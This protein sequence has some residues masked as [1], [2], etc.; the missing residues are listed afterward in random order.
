LG[1]LSQIVGAAGLVYLLA[2]QALGVYNTA[3][4]FAWT[5]VIPKSVTSVLITFFV[6]MVLGIATKTSEDYSRVWFFSWISISLLT[7]VGFRAIL[8]AVI[9]A[10]LA[11]GACLQRALIVTC[12]ENTLTGEQLALE[13]KNRIRAVGAITAPDLESIP[14]LG[15]Y[16]R[17]LNP[18]VVVLNLPWSRADAAMSKLKALSHHAVEVLILPR[19]SDGLQHAIRVRHLGSQVL[20][21]VAEPPLAAWGIAA[22]RAE[23]L[24]VAGAALF[25]IWPLL[26]LI[27]LAIKLDSKGPVLFK[28]KR[29]GFNG[30]L[31]EVWKFRSMHVDGTDLHASQQT[32]KDDPRVTR[33]GRFIRRASLDELPQFWN[34][35]QGQMSVV[36]PR[37]H[38]IATSAEGQAL[39]VLVEEYAARHR[40]KPG[41][42]GWAQVNGA[43]GE[44]NS[45]DQVKRRVDYDL[46]Y[47]NN[48]SVLFDLKITMMTA[49]RVIYDP[50]AY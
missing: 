31:I 19:S 10:R 26:L 20:L 9:E 43:R 22:K 44:L 48:W 30:N 38:A 46:Y 2:A 14:D 11:K 33:V 7:M 42:T 21:Q 13:T 29:A 5:Q 27:A 45:R 18:E 49:L 23:D 17:R 3:H 40:V 16:L 25:M 28:Q 37:P 15:P 39:E 12:G 41:I 1:Q 35:L 47:I 50:H 34:V 8:L 36:G 6:L 4:S 32:S 24:I